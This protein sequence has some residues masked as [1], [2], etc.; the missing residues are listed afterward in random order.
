MTAAT[1][2]KAVQYELQDNVYSGISNFWNVLIEGKA[3]P[4]Q[5]SRIWECYNSYKKAEECKGL[6]TNQSIIIVKEKMTETQ[7]WEWLDFFRE[8]FLNQLNGHI[9][10]PLNNCK[11]IIEANAPQI[12]GQYCNTRAMN[13]TI[14]TAADAQ[15]DF[16]VRSC[17]LSREKPQWKDV[18]VVAKFTKKTDTS[19]RKAKFTQL[20]RHVCEIFCA[21]PLQLFVHCFIFLKKNLNYGYFIA[22]VPT[23]QA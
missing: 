19:A 12:R 23:A 21:Q 4:K 6:E 1:L 14:S 2:A 7:V 5:T 16:I 9:E 10:E 13:S 8:K 11:V 20:S 17:E 15:A 3:W 18:R 22:Q